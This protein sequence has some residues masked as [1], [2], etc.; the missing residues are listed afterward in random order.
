MLP[1]SSR[2]PKPP[3]CLARQVGL[4]M[5]FMLIALVVMLI[6]AVAMIRSFDTS[7]ILAGNLGFKRD[8]VNEGE[9]GVAAA[10]AELKLAG[11]N[12]TPT[13]SSSS[14]STASFANLNYSAVMLPTN[15]QGVP[16]ALVDDSQFSTYGSTAN[17]ISSTNNDQVKIRYLI[18][19]QCNAVGVFNTQNCLSM[20]AINV[21]QG[22]DAIKN[23]NGTTN[24]VIFRISVRVTGPRNTQ[25]YLQTTAA[26]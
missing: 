7:L 21:K 15:S 17:D 1:L 25:V 13:S 14:T 3:R 5:P 26:M 19:R 4:V 20:P 24:A 22:T 23:P 10:F 8:L 11:N 6:S 2:M 9:R 12:F 16:T 18:D